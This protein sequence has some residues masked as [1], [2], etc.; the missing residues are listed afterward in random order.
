[1]RNDNYSAKGLGYG[2]AYKK[3]ADDLYWFFLFNVVHSQHFYLKSNA[4]A[5]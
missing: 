2:Y 3:I 4:H 5:R 1:M